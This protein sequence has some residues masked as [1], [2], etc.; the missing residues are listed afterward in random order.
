MI[1]PSVFGL[2]D[3]RRCESTRQTSARGKMSC[4]SK[5]SS[6][7]SQR[8]KPN[9]FSNFP[10]FQKRNVKGRKKMFSKKIH[11]WLETITLRWKHECKY[12]GVC[13]FA[14]G[15]FDWNS[16]LISGAVSLQKKV[17]CCQPAF[18]NSSFFLCIKLY[19]ALWHNQ[20]YFE[21]TPEKRRKFFI[22]RATTFFHVTD[23]KKKKRSEK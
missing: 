3:Q 14:K 12:V 22:A 9:A 16:V 15:K 8:K 10:L 17:L 7:N 18:M 4:T 2:K 1:S 11:R 19:F 20:V 5:I 23:I 21:H 13:L 6:Q